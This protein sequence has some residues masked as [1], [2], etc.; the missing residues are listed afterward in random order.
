MKYCK[1][2]NGTNK[3]N[4]SNPSHAYL[5]SGLLL[6]LFFLVV[7]PLSSLS[8]RIFLTFHPLL[9]PVVLILIPSF[10]FPFFPFL[11]LHPAHNNIADYR[12]HITKVTAS[13]TYAKYYSYCA[14]DVDISTRC[15][16]HIHP[17]LSQRTS[18]ENYKTIQIACHY[19][20]R[21]IL[22]LPKQRKYY[23]YTDTNNK[24]RSQTQSVFLI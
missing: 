11:F 14:V 20:V 13:V 6:L 4:V 10:P 2:T 8:H 15:K 19:K 22:Y 18:D 21:A 3:D 7:L 16:T 5:V 23:K 12:R 24:C 17:C 1:W 9:I